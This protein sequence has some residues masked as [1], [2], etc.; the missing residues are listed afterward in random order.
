MIKSLENKL[1][2]KKV[3][4]IMEK[5]GR[6][7]CILGFKNTVKKIKIKSDNIQMLIKNLQE[8]YKRSS[9]FE[10]INK[11]TIIS[12]HYGC[13]LMIKSATKL[14][15]S[16]TFCYFCLGHGKE[17]FEIALNVPLVGT[18]IE[19]VMKGANNCKFRF[20]F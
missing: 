11:N 2:K 18:I 1:G 6:K 15:S 5:E 10:Y 9:F 16:K 20:K 8:H 13:Y 14:I 19:T 12:G 7:S 4:E 3:N 17:F